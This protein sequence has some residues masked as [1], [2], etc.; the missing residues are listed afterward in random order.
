[1]SRPWNVEDSLVP[2][3]QSVFVISCT[4]SMPSRCSTKREQAVI[5]QHEILSAFRLGDDRFA[6]AAHR[7][8]DDD[9]EDRARGIVRRGAI[10]KARAIEDGK[11]RHMM[12]EVDDAHFRHDRIHDAAADGNGV[13]YYAEVAHE[14]DGLWIFRGLRRSQRG[15]DE[16]QQHR[17]H[18]PGQ[19][20]IRPPRAA[21]VFLVCGG[22]GLKEYGG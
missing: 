11:R 10:K 13:V 9:H 18:E 5:G 22:H 8:V 12:R 3:I 14:D 15:S 6:R 1:M 20:V 19:T 4:P 21:G 17:N 7:G 2:I 16:N